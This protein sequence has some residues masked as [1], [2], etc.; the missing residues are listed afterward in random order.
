MLDCDGE[1][2]ESNQYY[3]L[4]NLGKSTAQ[5]QEFT[6]I[7][8]VSLKRHN[9]VLPAFLNPAKAIYLVENYAKYYCIYERV[10]T[11]ESD[12]T[13]DEPELTIFLV[14][15]DPNEEK[16]NRAK[17]ILHELFRSETMKRVKFSILLICIENT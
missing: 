15:K 7:D 14:V 16:K 13:F 4:Y 6:P 11:S 17:K 3:Q 9:V 1:M 5:S 2:F 10:D 8:F 12:Q